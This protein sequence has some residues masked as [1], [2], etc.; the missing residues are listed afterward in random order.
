MTFFF[1]CGR[2]NGFFNI[3]RKTFFGGTY[4][5]APFTVLPNLEF[6]P[7]RFR[8]LCKKNP[9]RVGNTAPFSQQSRKYMVW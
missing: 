7:E 1:F 4:K 9:S 6:F 5:E 3:K 8:G 2:K